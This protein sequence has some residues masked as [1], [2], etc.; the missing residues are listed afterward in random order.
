MP[1]IIKTAI[2]TNL[3]MRVEKRLQ[4]L[5]AVSWFVLGLGLSFGV[6]QGPFD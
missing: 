4:M 2:R 3:V 6:P 1:K 5:M